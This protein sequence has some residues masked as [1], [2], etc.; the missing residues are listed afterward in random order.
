MD[1]NNQNKARPSDLLK[2][3]Q[4]TLAKGLLDQITPVFESTREALFSMAEKAG[5]TQLQS[6][7][8]E[9]ARQLRDQRT[10]FTNELNQAVADLFTD[11]RDG[12]A[13]FHV[14]EPEPATDYDDSELQLIEEH[15]LEESLAISDLVA[16]AE[17]RFTQTIYALNQRLA[18]LNRGRP[19]RSDNN[20]CGPMK[21]SKALKQAGSALDLA[22]EHRVILYR[23][24]DDV[25]Q[26]ALGEIYQKLNDLLGEAGILPNIK[27][28]TPQRRATDRPGGASPDPTG[29]EADS[30]PETDFFGRAVEQATADDSGG[31]ANQLLSSLR[32]LLDARRGG[33]ALQPQ[34]I[35]PTEQLA[36]VVDQLRQRAAPDQNQPDAP[37]PAY[38]ADQL[39]ELLEKQLGN[40]PSTGESYR[41][42]HRHNQTVDIVGMLYEFVQEEIAVHR[43]VQGLL[44]KL[45]MPML[46]LA[47]KE[48]NFFEDREH[49]AR[50][51]F[52]TIADAGEL[53]LEDEGKRSPTLKKIEDTI[54][55]AANEYQGD[56]EVFGELLGDVNRH[57]G[58]LN[59]R[60]QL[61]EKRNIEA[62]RGRERLDTARSRASKLI[63]EL[64]RRYKPPALVES[65][66]NEAWTDYLALVVLR[67]GDESEQW[68]DGVKAAKTLTV[69]VRNDLEES[70]RVKIHQRLPWLREQL[71][72]GLAQVGYFQS[73]I[74]QIVADLDECQIWA[75][76]PEEVAE[77]GRPPESLAKRAPSN[78]RNQPTPAITQPKVTDAPAPPAPERE[79]E[80]A[81]TRE[82]SPAKAAQPESSTSAEDAGQLP[83]DVEP[84]VPT[85]NIGP[86]TSSLGTTADPVSAS[87]PEPATTAA[88]TTAPAPVPAPPATVSPAPVSEAAVSADPAAST[89]EL[90]EEELSEKERSW[91]AKLRIVPFGT[92]FEL[93]TADGT[94]A[95]RKLSWYSP[96][97]GRCLFVNN[98]GARA[99]DIL[100]EVL[101][102][103][104]ASNKARLYR[105]ASKPLMDRALEWM[106]S[107]LRRPT[108]K[109][110]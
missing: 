8:H 3:C 23:R 90:H 13:E 44:N 109:T 26:D 24:F 52:N 33:G 77:A 65:L 32:G 98:R 38:T 94:W 64:V 91:L 36:Q 14:S 62:A 57:V 29:S 28:A 74:D 17:V 71:N 59:R 101:A 95:K 100:M 50:Q 9:G 1:K 41:L 46:Q 55:R 63:E 104:M 68:D 47:L 22:S 107:K 48:D 10:V 87:T 7:L 102:R 37:A 106:F 11:F 5:S 25:L 51:F 80:P 56:S 18:V 61:A 2:Q 54:E 27:F 20:P 19:V 85:D 83:V 35:A 49:P 40:D 15:E 53:W 92:W 79:P 93:Q 72:T 108:G 66:L 103:D 16:K 69:S 70:L 30:G 39:R 58:S 88:P 73:D 75:L 43:R 86:E 67:H 99:G 4:N 60:A 6:R 31:A 45:Q 96:I 12:S 105:P 21:I 81:P 82:T 78:R 76:S 110:A 97:T 42:S 84:P 89:I 34:A